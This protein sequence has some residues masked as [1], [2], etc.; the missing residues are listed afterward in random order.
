MNEQNSIDNKTQ[1][2]YNDNIMTRKNSIE[3]STDK[4]FKKS[5]QESYKLND[6]IDQI[7]LDV[8]YDT[9]NVTNNENTYF[10]ETKLANLKDK[11]NYIQEDKSK[12]VVNTYN[13]PPIYKVNNEKHKQNLGPSFGP[14]EYQFVQ[15]QETIENKIT[16]NNNFQQQNLKTITKVGYSSIIPK[17]DN[18]FNK[19][20]KITPNPLSSIANTSHPGFN[21]LDKTGLKFERRENTKPRALSVSDKSQQ[22]DQNQ[23]EPRRSIDVNLLI[24]QNT[25]K[26]IVVE[27]KIEINS[28]KKQINSKNIQIKNNPAA[29]LLFYNKPSTL[30]I[31]QPQR[32]T[33][34]SNPQN[35]FTENKKLK[36]IVEEKITIVDDRAYSSVRSTP[37]NAQQSSGGI[38]DNKSNSI[39]RDFFISQI[40]AKTGQNRD[41]YVKKET[42]Y[43]KNI[44]SI[45][46]DE[47]KNEDQEA[48]GKEF[49]IEKKIEEYKQGEKVRIEGF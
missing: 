47:S 32:Q 4:N 38:L 26:K 2:K 40:H 36:Q 21:G 28:D 3:G 11:H 43:C 25:R 29:K 20:I 33:D 24:N 49:E 42:I 5:F 45:N 41:S 1:S 12:S 7:N 17:A 46:L 44:Q 22:V 39:S 10:F 13:K 14:G 15:R 37:R 8:N 19:E 34:I 6:Q 31:E 18:P 27:N 30:I 23:P 9:S 16:K 48:G 35:M